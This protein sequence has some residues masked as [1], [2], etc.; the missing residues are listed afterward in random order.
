M[1]QKPIVIPAERIWDA[2]KPRF[3]GYACGHG[4]HRN[5]KAYT[6]KQKHRREL[7]YKD[8]SGL[9]M[10]IIMLPIMLMLLHG[11]LS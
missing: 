11:V 5:K 2:H 4:A 3:N 8:G 10:L 7:S 1:K 6:R 9:L